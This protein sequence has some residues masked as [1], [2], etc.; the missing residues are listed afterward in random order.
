MLYDPPLGTEGRLHV[1]V[2]LTSLD[3]PR[4]IIHI[5]FVI[6]FLSLFGLIC[7]ISLPPRFNILL[8]DN[9]PRMSW[10]ENTW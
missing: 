9:E 6:I 3:L 5:T 2:V 10:S 4:F 7:L 8:E 1:F